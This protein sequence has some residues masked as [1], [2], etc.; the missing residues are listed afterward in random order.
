MDIDIKKLEK[1]SKILVETESGVYEIIVSS[2]KTGT[3]E[4]S[5]GEA[6]LRPVKAKIQD[7]KIG[8]FKQIVFFYKE[9]NQPKEVRTAKVLSARI[10]GADGS[11]HFD[12]IENEN[13][14]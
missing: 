4:V 7:S 2:Q 6:F 13:S 10:Y 5:G 14:N 12:A 3:V 9:K 8:K 11:W 1:N